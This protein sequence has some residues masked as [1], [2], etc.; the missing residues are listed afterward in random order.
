MA[1]K[2]NESS[3]VKEAMKL[4]ESYSW[5]G[6]VRELENAIERAMIFADGPLQPEHFELNGQ[7]NHS[8]QEDSKTLPEIAA[9][10]LKSAEIEAITRALSETGGNK[11]KAAK[12]L[13]VS[14]KTLLNKIK[15]YELQSGKKTAQE[16]KIQ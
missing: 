2:K 14:Y 4:L 16:A 12:V 3:V 6:N 1:N 7:G 15:D 13:G 11:S 8:E 10:A 9:I 5:P